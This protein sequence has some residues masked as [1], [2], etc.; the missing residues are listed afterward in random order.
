MRRGMFP[1]GP[2]ILASAL[3]LASSMAAA[4]LTQ[5][6]RDAMV[7]AHDVVRGAATPY[8][9]PLLAGVSWSTP[10]ETTSQAW[11]TLCMYAHSGTPGV[12][13]NISAFASIPDPVPRPHPDAPVVSWD[14]ERAFYNYAANT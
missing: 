11:A 4:Q 10:L 9:V 5:A 12:G 3:W 13:E 2:W 7:Y 14:S 1:F 6:E 8:P